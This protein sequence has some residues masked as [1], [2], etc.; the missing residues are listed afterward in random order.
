MIIVGVFVILSA[1]TAQRHCNDLV[2]LSDRGLRA[3]QM[4]K[5]FPR[6]LGG[7][8]R[9]SSKSRRES[10]VIDSRPLTTCSQAEAERIMRARM[11]L[12]IE[13][14]EVRREAEAVVVVPP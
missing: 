1:G 7:L 12:L 2:S 5:R 6:N 13:G 9:P 4:Y 11:V 14:N 10:R 8:L 3:G